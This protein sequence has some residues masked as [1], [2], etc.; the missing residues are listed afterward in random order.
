MF[1]VAFRGMLAAKNYRYL[2][3]I[4]HRKCYFYLDHGLTDIIALRKVFD[5]FRMLLQ[6]RN[7]QSFGLT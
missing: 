4:I 6:I 1:A 2:E 5:F 7:Q 3:D